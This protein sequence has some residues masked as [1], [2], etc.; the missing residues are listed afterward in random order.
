MLL[1]FELETYIEECCDVDE[2]KE[3][4]DSSKERLDKLIE[5]QEE[6]DS[7]CIPC[8]NTGKENNLCDEHYDILEN[9]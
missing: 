8:L 7:I 5:I 2:L 3:I 1:P 6:E 9:K 4:I